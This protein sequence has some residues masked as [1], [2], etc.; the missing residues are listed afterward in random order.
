FGD[1]TVGGAILVEGLAH[2]ADLPP[3]AA[4]PEA[5]AEMFRSRT[6]VD[7]GSAGAKNP[8]R[9]AKGTDHAPIRDSSKGPGEHHRVELARAVGQTFGLTD[10]ILDATRIGPGERAASIANA[11][12]VRIDRHDPG[13]EPREPPGESSFAAADLQHAV[14]A[15]GSQASECAHLALL[16][17]DRDRHAASVW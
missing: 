17:I 2:D 1:G 5:D 11:R 8:V 12:G 6:Q 9:F 10:A 16:R 4:P 7:Q 15:P 14:A 3:A 13:A